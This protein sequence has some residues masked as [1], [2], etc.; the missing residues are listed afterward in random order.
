MLLSGCSDSLENFNPVNF[1]PFKQPEQRLPGERRGILADTAATAPDQAAGGNVSIPGPSGLSAWAQPGG[2][3]SNAPG[4]VSLTPGQPWSA[5]VA[6]VERRGRLAASPVVDDGRAYVMA[7]DG[8]VSAFSISGGGRA[9]SVSTR[10]EGERGRGYGG[11]LASGSGVL[12]VATP[13]KSVVGLDPA[14]GGVVWTSNV[15]APPRGAPTV[16][17]GTAYVVTSD[18]VLVALNVADGSE[19]WRHRGIGEATGVFGSAS[20][21]VSGGKVV[22][23]YSS[24]EIIVFNASDGTPAW[25]DAL[26]GASRL[27]SVSGIDDVSRPVVFDGTVYAVSVSG[28]M[29]ATSLSN[30]ERRW[31][32]SVASSH[33]PAV[34]G[35]SIFVATLEGAVVALDRATGKIRWRTPVT[36]D[37]GSR[38]DLAGPLLAGSQ[39]WVG[40]SDGRVLIIDPAS[41]QL[42][43]AQNVGNP[44]FLPPIA[45]GGRVLVLDNAGNL[46]AVN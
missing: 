12:V 2:V 29:I 5:R 8:T 38:V 27:T 9:W 3:P 41:G 15:P 23:P 22:V 35:N 34:A 26:T 44:V 17:D 14:T 37:R 4:N 10:P 13:Y 33:T 16:A 39:L 31:A 25:L 7:T 24:G 11:G 36:N 30:G 19:K 18:N 6:E 40:T 45:A 42:T 43:G 46:S 32:Q 20:P 28:R 1:N 21:A